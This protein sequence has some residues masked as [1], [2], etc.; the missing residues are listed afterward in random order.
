MKIL[1]TFFL[2][3]LFILPKSYATNDSLKQVTFGVEASYHFSDL[4]ERF[5]SSFTVEPTANYLGILG[6]AEF[7]VMERMRISTGIGLASL[8]FSNLHN[9]EFNANLP[10]PDSIQHRNI[11]NV[12]SKELMI[13]STVTF[14][15]DYILNPKIYFILGFQPQFRLTSNE[16]NNYLGTYISNRNDGPV[17]LSDPDPAPVFSEKGFTLTG[18]LGVGVEIRNIALEFT[19]RKISIDNFLLNFWGFRLRYKI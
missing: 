6:F 16:S 10:Q 18:E 19:F 14:R 9:N 1:S 12:S 4:P 13:S 7:Q 15:F 2:L 5:T 17:I 8:S 11:Y 3:F